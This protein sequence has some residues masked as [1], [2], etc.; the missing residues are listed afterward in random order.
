MESEIIVEDW[1]PVGDMQAFVEKTDR[2]YF[3]YLW[4]NPESEEPELK[5]CWVCNRVKAAKDMKEAFVQEGAAFCTLFT[6]ADNH[7]RKV[8]ERAG[9]EPVRQFDLMSITVSRRN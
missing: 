4:L 8:Y 9:L 3:F 1:S 7:A 2:T 5:S 6:G